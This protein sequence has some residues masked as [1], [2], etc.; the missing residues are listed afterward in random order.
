[1]KS[2][3]VLAIVVF[4]LALL[5]NSASGPRANDQMEDTAADPIEPFNRVVFQINEGIQTLVIRPLAELYTLFLPPPIRNRIS[6]VLNNLRAPVVLANDLLQG[7]GE[8]AWQTTQRIFINS[9]LGVGGLWDPADSLG[10]P[11]HDEDFGQTLATWGVDEGLYLVLPI[12]GPSNPR[13]AIGKYGVDTLFDPLDLYLANTH[14]TTEAWARTGISGIDTFSNIKDELDQVKKTSVDYYAGV[15]SMYRQKR[16][17]QILNGRDDDQPNIPDLSRIS[18]P[19]APVVNAGERSWRPIVNRASSPE[20][21]WAASVTLAG[22][23]PTR[24]EATSSWQP[25]VHLDRKRIPG[26]QIMVAELSSRT[27]P[28]IRP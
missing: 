2:K 11:G 9:T 17:A 18:R 1:M 7:E 26:G 13:D 19:E 12:L 10:I 28:R 15:R 16:R 27:A 4:S 20:T 21:G 3:K 8:R 14:R 25:T 6:N 5:T 23:A 22:R 24:H